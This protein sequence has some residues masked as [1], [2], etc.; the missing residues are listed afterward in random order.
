MFSEKFSVPG[1]GFR[2]EKKN[3]SDGFGELEGR[4]HMEAMDMGDL[5]REDVDDEASRL[6]I[7]EGL[8]KCKKGRTI[9]DPAFAVCQSLELNKLTS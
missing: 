2:R 6:N 8:G 4:Q 5:F 9:S 7:D 3:L 1:T